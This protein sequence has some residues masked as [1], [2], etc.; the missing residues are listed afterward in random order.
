MKTGSRRG[1]RSLIMSSPGTIT[2]WRSTYRTSRMDLLTGDRMIQPRIGGC[3]CR[4]R[5][6]GSRTGILPPNF[7]FLSREWSGDIRWK[8]GTRK[9]VLWIFPSRYWIEWCLVLIPMERVW[10]HRHRMMWG[11]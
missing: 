1:L 7:C 6:P 5:F 2:S 4:R 3:L 11:A 9:T 8:G 10:Y